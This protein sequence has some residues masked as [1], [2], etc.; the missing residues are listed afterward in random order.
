M[1][2]V[3]NTQFDALLFFFPKRERDL[4]FHLPKRLFSKEVVLYSYASVTL[5]N[6]KEEFKMLERKTQQEIIIRGKPYERL[7]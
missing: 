6:G 2:S 4:E 1:V 5:N 7:M 3:N